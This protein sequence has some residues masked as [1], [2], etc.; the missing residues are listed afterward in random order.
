MNFLHC[1]ADIFFYPQIFNLT[2]F[3]LSSLSKGRER[4]KIGLNTAKTSILIALG[5]CQS[6]QGVGGRNRRSV[7]INDSITTPIPMKIGIQISTEYQFL[8]FTRRILSIGGVKSFFILS[9]IKYGTGS[10]QREMANRGSIAS[11]HGE[12]FLALK[13][14]S[15]SIHLMKPWCSRDYLT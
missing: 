13:H 12:G 4:L 8:S 3:R 5:G 1:R 10:L 14:T 7:L 2:L 15:R 9:L 6:R 11:N